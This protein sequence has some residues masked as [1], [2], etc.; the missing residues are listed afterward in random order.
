[1]T[2]LEIH[3]RRLDTSAHEA[4]T[5]FAEAGAAAFGHRAVLTIDRQLAQL[6]RLRVAQIGNCSYC[7]GVHQAAARAAGIPQA[8]IDVLAA[9]WE[10]GLFTDAE[11][12]ALQ[13]AEGLTRASDTSVVQAFQQHHDALA[14]HF[15]AKA[16]LEIV[17]VVIN[18]NVW[19]RL[20]LAA[21]ATPFLP[22][23]DDE[24]GGPST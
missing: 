6:L 17:A 1:M 12:A 7:L 19:I 4:L 20:K 5:N 9:W 14:A 11:Q 16:M 21:G 23:P 2:G 22:R 10:T 13:Y 18:M 24:S 8:K 15:D 3:D